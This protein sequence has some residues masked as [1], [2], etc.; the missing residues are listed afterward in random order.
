[1]VT[2]EQSSNFCVVVRL[3]TLW[4]QSEL[5]TESNFLYDKINVTCIIWVRNQQHLDAVNDTWS[6]NCNHFHYFNNNAKLLQT[7]IL[8]WKDFCEQFINVKINDDW[9]LITNDFTYVLLSNL[10]LFLTFFDAKHAHYFGKIKSFWNLDYNEIQAGIVLSFETFR[11]LRIVIRDNDVCNRRHHNHKIDYILGNLLDNIGIKPGDTKDSKNLTTFH[12]LNLNRIVE[13]ISQNCCSRYLITFNVS[14]KS[15]TFK[16][17]I[18]N[19]KFLG[20]GKYQIVHIFLLIG[21]FGDIQ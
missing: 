12:T 13:K 19:Y 14:L 15:Q 1:M 20:D 11:R 18:M 5:V 21:D 2:K 16:F 9:V 6:K 4:Q 7:N 8:K 10:R 3:H 17:K